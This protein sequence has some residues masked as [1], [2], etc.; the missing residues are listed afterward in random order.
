[1]TRRCETFSYGGC[2]GNNNRFF[3]QE[4]CEEACVPPEN[5][6]NLIDCRPGSTCRVN[7]VTGVGECVFVIDRCDLF[8]CDDGFRC[9]VNVLTNE[10]ECVPNVNPC[11]LILCGIPSICRVDPVTGEGRC[12]PNPCDTLSCSKLYECRYDPKSDEGVCVPTAPCLLKDCPRGQVCKLNEVTREGECAPPDLRCMIFSC[13]PGTVCDVD[14]DVRSTVRCVP[15][16]PCA[17]LNCGS[18]ICRIDRVSGTGYCGINPCILARCRD[19]QY[20]PETDDLQCGTVDP[21]ATVLC[22]EDTVCRVDPENGLPECVDPCDDVECGTLT[23]RINSDNT[24]YCGLDPC[25]YTTCKTGQSCRYNRRRDSPECVTVDPCDTIRCAEGTRCEVDSGTGEARCVL[26]V[27]DIR[28][29]LLRCPAGFTCQV[30]SDQ[31]TVECVPDD[32]CQ[33]RFCGELICR[34]DA[35]TRQ[36]YCGLDPCTHTTCEPGSLC[37]YSPKLDTA[38]CVA[39]QTDPCENINCPSGKTCQ[40]NPLGEAECVR[41]NTRCNGILCSGG[42]I[43][44]VNPTTGEE[45]CGITPCAFTT[46]PTNTLC[47]YDPTTDR[48]VCRDNGVD[49][50]RDVR[51]DPFRRC[52]VQITATP[53]C[54]PICR[55]ILCGRPLVCRINSTTREPYCGD[56]PC[57]SFTCFNPQTECQYDAINDR[58]VCG[59]I[60]TSVPD[61]CDPSPC[62]PNTQCVINSDSNPECRGIIRG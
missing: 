55:N 1:M 61:L 19:C 54:V 50:C 4:E 17:H 24:A 14:R 18:Q 59:P 35:V 37:E 32:P 6:C 44:R 5:P 52:E 62:P 51:C 22:S 47:E 42:D 36:P 43:C 27:P 41:S 28:C 53:A 12:G 29:F 57:R 40:L 13:P 45:F 56:G 23:C 3:T 21:C 38:V 9:R 30:S 34:I 26:D 10:P 25:T 58:P 8:P 15:D 20:N 16:H 11:A 49:L 46:C 60:L 2:G 39:P 31:L 33:G 48:A 7:P